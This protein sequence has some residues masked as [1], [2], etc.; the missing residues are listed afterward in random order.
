MAESQYAFI[1]APTKGPRNAYLR[2]FTSGNRIFD[3]SGIPEVE[4]VRCDWMRPPKMSVSPESV[5]TV[6]GSFT[7]TPQAASIESGQTA[8]LQVTLPNP[9]PAGGFPVT[10]A[11]SNTGVA[12]VPASVTVPAG[13]TNA[14]FL[15]TA[16]AGGTAVISAANNGNVQATANITVTGASAIVIAPV[17]GLS[18]GSSVALD[19]TLPVP[20]SS[21]MSVQLSSSNTGI[22]T[23]SPS[24]AFILAG[25]TKPNN[26]PLVSGQN[27]GNATITAQAF[28]YASGTRQV[29]VGSTLSF[30]PT[31]VTVNA[32]ATQSVQVLLGAP[33][34]AG[35]LQ[36]TL[37]SS[38]NSVA[39]APALVNIPQN[40]SGVSFQLTGGTGGT[41]WT[42]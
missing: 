31:A 13:S 35:G 27:F 26:P 34:P 18:P 16:V 39:S 32:G 33:A 19:I 12:T 1:C 7:L 5:V 2:A 28:G 17:T 9:A 40:S 38:N 29:T 22:A 24:S 42:R 15:V 23:V 11:S 4:N 37:T 21:N 25:A 20:A 41:A 6:T 10:L 36:V 3:S 30:S 14:Q 8:T